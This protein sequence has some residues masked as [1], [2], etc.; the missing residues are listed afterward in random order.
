MSYYRKVSLL[1]TATAVLLI[2]LALPGRA[3][4]STMI[5]SHAR[6]AQGQT[7]IIPRT[8]SGCNYQGIGVHWYN[9]TTVVGGGLKITSISGY[10]VNYLRGSQ[11]NMHVEIYGPNGLIKNCAP[12]TLPGGGQG[13]TCTWNN[14]NPNATMTAGDYCSVAWQYQGNNYYEEG[15]PECIGVHA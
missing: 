7:K 5:H 14:P 12:F 4:G 1:L 9:C 8:G 13:P 2:G 11:S 15:A 3:L 10:T 6:L